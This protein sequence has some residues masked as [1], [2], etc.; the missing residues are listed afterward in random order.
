MKHSSIYTWITGAVLFF[1]YLPIVILILYSFND[2]RF[3]GEWSGFTL[4]WYEKLWYESDLWQAV[5]NSLVIAISTTFVSTIL[6]TSAAFALHRYRTKLQTIHY[7]FI[8]TPLMIPD[9]LTG[10]GLLLF[11]IALNIKLGLFSIFI[12]HTTFCISYVTMVIQSKLQNFDFTF[13][14]AAQDLGAN[15]WTII[16]RILFPLLTPGLTAGALLAF[17][18]SIDDF[19]ITYFVAGHGVSTLPIYIYSMIKFGSI[20]IINALSVVIL[21]ITAIIIIIT[22]K[23]SKED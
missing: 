21:S 5:G 4:K 10:V 6:G 22:Q 17:M 12:A 1:L 13:L 7:G 9:I 14:E 11:F 16:R 3:G 15:K 8:Y 18:L 19:I 20:P 2:S 23:L